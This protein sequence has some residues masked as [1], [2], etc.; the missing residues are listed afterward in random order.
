METNDQTKTAGAHV[1]STDELWPRKTAM[2]AIRDYL[3]SHTMARRVVLMA[4]TPLFFCVWLW[5]AVRGAACG[6]VRGAIAETDT[7]DLLRQIRRVWIGDEAYFNEVQAARLKQAQDLWADHN[8]E[9][10]RRP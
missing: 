1:C 8:T 2:D 3:Q 5:L 4:H 10:Q 7:A 6:A 9:V